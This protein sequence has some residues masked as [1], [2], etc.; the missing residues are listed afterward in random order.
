MF[1]LNSNIYSTMFVSVTSH[2]VYHSK[3]FS[4]Y[5]CF[6]LEF[7]MWH[8]FGGVHPRFFCCSIFSFLCSALKIIVCFYSLGHWIDCTRFVLPWSI[9][10]LTSPNFW[11]LH[12]L[13][14][15]LRLLFPFNISWLL[16]QYFLISTFVPSDLPFDV[17]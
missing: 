4:L 17:F 14:F 15:D 13:S 8:R 11:T 5:F 9:S 16:L 6:V 12:F 1:F 10:P 2:T 3:L 7:N